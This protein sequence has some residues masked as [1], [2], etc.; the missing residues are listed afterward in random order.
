VKAMLTPTQTV[1]PFFHDCLLRSDICANAL[2]VPDEDAAVIR[3]HGFV[4]DGDGVGVPDAMIEWWQTSA[5]EKLSVFG[6]AGTAVDGSYELTTAYPASIPSAGDVRQSP[7]LS[8]AIFAR[9]LLNHL[10]TRVYLP[11][12]ASNAADPI[13]SRVPVTRRSTLIARE[14]SPAVNGDRVYRFDVVL[15]GPG[16]TVFLDFK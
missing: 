9:G 13:L 16:E 15:Q 6:R 5:K 3:V 10:L 1:G 11:N 8:L 7:H 14:E 12:D 4:Y 2:A